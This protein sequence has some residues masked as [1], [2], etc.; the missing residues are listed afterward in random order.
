MNQ[1]TGLLA[2]KQAPA[3]IAFLSILNHFVGFPLAVKFVSYPILVFVYGGIVFQQPRL[4]QDTASTQTDAARALI[5]L[6]ASLLVPAFLEVCTKALNILIHGILPLLQVIEIFSVIFFLIMIVPGSTEAGY[7]CDFEGKTL[8]YKLNG[9]AV[10][11]ATVAVYSSL[12]YFGLKDASYL[13]VHFFECWFWAA[14]IGLALAYA[15]D[16]KARELNPIDANYQRCLTRDQVITANLD[17]N[18]DNLNNLLSTL[19]V[20]T[21]KLWALEYFNGS[22]FNPR[23][24]GVDVKMAL[25][26]LGAV[27]LQLN[28]ASMV[29]LHSINNGGVVANAVALYASL[30]TWFLI[31][32]SYF[33]N[34][35][36]YTYDLFAEK[37]GA[38]LIFGCLGFY[39]YLYCIGGIVLTTY[40]P[41]HSL[42]DMSLT[43][44]TLTAFLFFTGWLLTRGANMQKFYFK[45]NP[46][47]PT[48]L[49]NLIPQTTIPSSRLLCSG[50]WGVS[51]HV[52]Y[53]G[54][55]IQGIALALPGFLVCEGWWAVVPWL[56]PV[57]YVCL[58]VPRERDD[59]LICAKKY[60]VVWEEYCRV[61]KWRI[62]PFVY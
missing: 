29:A 50:F 56:Y 14:A 44:C 41:H 3:A 57:Y 60:G 17:T 16:R 32:Y 42:P 36:L 24:L 38:K 22:F 15:A 49:F 59:S 11:F 47:A 5:A 46:T 6:L 20:N 30:F 9:L 13:A 39:P 10:L 25:Y 62:V 53:L 37:V 48:V 28:I 52:N 34:V 45:T 19:P 18:P 1:A 4:P 40:S 35:H 58:F 26:C 7:T 33:E 55:I 54:E 8:S 12:C 21:N 61:V 2:L 43:T 51:R 31:E 27:M 23:F